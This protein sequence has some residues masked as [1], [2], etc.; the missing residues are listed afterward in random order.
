MNDLWI[1]LSSLI[2]W[3]I[4]GGGRFFRFIPKIFIPSLPCI[5]LRKHCFLF[6]VL[7]NAFMISTG[8]EEKAKKLGFALA[9]ITCTSQY[10]WFLI[11][12]NWWEH[13]RLFDRNIYFQKF[14]LLG[15]FSSLNSL[16][17]EKR[18]ASLETLGKNWQKKRTNKIPK[19]RSRGKENH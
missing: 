16:V 2:K 15:F 5:S 4:Q 18:A 10:L 19:K 12:Y 7:K 9:S 13:Q 11:V 1:K 3:N 14:N 17:K 8:A 6:L